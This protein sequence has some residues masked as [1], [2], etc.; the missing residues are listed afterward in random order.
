MNKI[1]RNFLVVVGAV[2]ALVVLYF[3]YLQTH[4]VEIA[5]QSQLASLLAGEEQFIQFDQPKKS[6]DCHVRGSLPDPDCTPG[7][8]FQDATK[9][10]VCVS[11]YSKTVRSVSVSLKKKVFSEYGISYPVPFGSYEVDHL[12]PL[13]LG[14]DNDIA[15]LFPESAEPYPGF[16][17]KDVVENYLHQEVCA[18]RVALSVAQ[19]QIADNWLE[20]YNN[21]DPRVV[22][23]FKKRFRSWADRGSE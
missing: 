4:Q 9:E 14:G 15:N 8:V 2:V 21:L 19:K 17:E 12:I 23:E 6:T 5:K 18:D 1:L 16:R 22:E 20:V 10:V 3:F 7:A 13:A 11:G